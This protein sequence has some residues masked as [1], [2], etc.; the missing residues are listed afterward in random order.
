MSIKLSSS[1]NYISSLGKSG[2]VARFFFFFLFSSRRR[3]TRF[4]RDWSSDVC[5]SDLGALDP[6]NRVG[7]RLAAGD[8][9]A[10]LAAAEL[11][12][13]QDRGLLPAGRG[14][15][16]DR[17]DPLGVIEPAQRLGEER[18]LAELCERLPVIQ[19]ESLAAPR[20]DEDRPD[21]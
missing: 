8:A 1:K 3:H 17:I 6:A 20:C 2:L 5:S 10:H 21:R 7:A 16:H 12:G 15:Q 11:L 14:D 9:G 13:Q 18:I 19:A 4:D